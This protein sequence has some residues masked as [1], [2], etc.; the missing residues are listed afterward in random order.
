MEVQILEAIKASSADVQAKI[1][2]V[3]TEVHHL[4]VDLC[5]VAERSLITEQHV[6]KLQEEVVALKTSV[7]TLTVKILS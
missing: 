5:K 7:T 6:N 3:S 1:D 2:T 4:R